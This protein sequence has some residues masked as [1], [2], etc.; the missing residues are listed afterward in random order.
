[1]QKACTNQTHS[2]KY[3]SY[4]ANKV[5]SG[6][7]QMVFRCFMVWQGEDPTGQVCILLIDDCQVP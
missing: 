2:T 7:F 4:L 6:G 3:P 1:M 5:L